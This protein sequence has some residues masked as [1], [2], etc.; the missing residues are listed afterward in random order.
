MNKVTVNL[1]GQN[2]KLFVVRDLSSM[3][4][5]QKISFMK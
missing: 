2:E 3:V 5:L 4:H 1:N